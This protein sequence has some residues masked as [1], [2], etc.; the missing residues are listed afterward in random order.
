MK[1]HSFVVTYKHVVPFY[2]KII[3]AE[4]YKIKF[5]NDNFQKLTHNI[6]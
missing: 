5:L 4:M 2:L 1:I 3:Q 6:L